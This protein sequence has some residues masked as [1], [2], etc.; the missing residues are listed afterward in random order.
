[1]FL[2]SMG[3]PVDG[4]ARFSHETLARHPFHQQQWSMMSDENSIPAE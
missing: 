2:E 3:M 4:D 1:M